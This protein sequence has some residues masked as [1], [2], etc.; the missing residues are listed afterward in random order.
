MYLNLIA[1]T[2]EHL[3]RIEEPRWFVLFIVLLLRIFP[4]FSVE[5]QILQTVL[6]KLFFLFIYFACLCVVF[7]SE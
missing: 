6:K 3:I 7:G 1:Y 2:L 4:S 5:F